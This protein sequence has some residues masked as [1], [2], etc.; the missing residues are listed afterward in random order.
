MRAA[1][2]GPAPAELRVEHVA[3]APG[4]ITVTARAC[5]MAV[6]CPACGHR[7]RRVH[8]W[9]VRTLA[10]LPWEGC[11]VRLVARVRKFVC[12]R[13]RCPRRIFVERLTQTAPP[14]ARRTGRASAALEA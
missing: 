7:A 11:R 2:L 10:D 9:Y 12:E 3:G 1:L 13:A 6:P 8:A 5:R 4:L 14:H